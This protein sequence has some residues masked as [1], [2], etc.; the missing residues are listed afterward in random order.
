M[1]QSNTRFSSNGE[2]VSLI[3]RRGPRSYKDSVK[4]VGLKPR[5]SLRGGWNCENPEWTG[6]LGIVLEDSSPTLQKLQTC[7]CIIHAGL[8]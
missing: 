5:A 1:M 4:Y 7:I 3:G 6:A 2:L 8:R